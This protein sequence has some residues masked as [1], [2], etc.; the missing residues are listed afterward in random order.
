M[1][2][3][4]VRVFAESLKMIGLKEKARAASV[5]AL[6]AAI[7][8][9]SDPSEHFPESYTCGRVVPQR[10][11]RAKVLN[12]VQTMMVP[13]RVQYIA[14]MYRLLG[15]MPQSRRWSCSTETLES[16][17]ERIARMLEA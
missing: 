16:D 7:G 11:A 6:T 5:M 2:F 17:I 1:I 3:T 14:L 13:S 9:H 15:W 12:N 8:Y 4:L 10:K